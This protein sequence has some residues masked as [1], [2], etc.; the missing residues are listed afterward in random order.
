MI[1]SSDP[2]EIL[3]RVGGGPDDGIDLAEAAL[4]LAALD[5]PLAPLDDYRTHLAGIAR[6]VAEACASGDVDAVVFVNDLTDYQRRWLST[7]LGRPVLTRADLDAST[8]ELTLPAQR[9]SRTGNGSPP[10]RR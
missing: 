7:R 3:R 2:R 1:E 10:R 4:A 5:L 9:S 6:E 8:S